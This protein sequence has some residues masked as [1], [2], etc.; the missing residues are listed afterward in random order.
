MNEL[1]KKE[2]EFILSLYKIEL[3]NKNNRSKSSPPI[4]KENTEKQDSEKKPKKK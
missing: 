3:K 1:I 2:Q 4:K